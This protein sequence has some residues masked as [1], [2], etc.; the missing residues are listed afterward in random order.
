MGCVRS[1]GRLRSHQWV[2]P[3]PVIPRTL[4]VKKTPD[5]T[6]VY[7]LRLRLCIAYLLYFF[8]SVSRADYQSIE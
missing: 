4:R 8:S 2:A 5:H 1:T 3:L 7:P 6:L